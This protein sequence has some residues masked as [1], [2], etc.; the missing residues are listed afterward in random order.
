MDIQSFKQ[1]IATF[2]LLK[3]NHVKNIFLMDTVHMVTDANIYTKI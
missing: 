1:K 2:L 3:Q